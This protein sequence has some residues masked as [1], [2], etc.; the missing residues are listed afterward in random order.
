MSRPMAAGGCGIDGTRPD[1]AAVPGAGF[2]GGISLKAA[3][4]QTPATI[5]HAAIRN[6]E[7]DVLRR[8]DAVIDR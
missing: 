6:V 7:V 2:T 1:D 4:T 3:K 8:S 5:Q